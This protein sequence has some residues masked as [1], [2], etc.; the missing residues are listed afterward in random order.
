M[1]LRLFIDLTK[2]YK[3]NNYSDLNLRYSS[4]DSLNNSFEFDIE[5][6]K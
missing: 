4:D 3:R 1:I 5:Q 2:G 6:E